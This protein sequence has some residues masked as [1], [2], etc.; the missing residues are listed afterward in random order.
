MK[1]WKVPTHP[2]GQFW[3]FVQCKFVKRLVWPLLRPQLIV[4]DHPW[5]FCVA[6]YFAEIG[7]DHDRLKYFVSTVIVSPCWV[8]HHLV[9]HYHL[10][11]RRR[12][13]LPALQLLCLLWMMAVLVSCIGVVEF[14]V[15]L[16][17]KHFLLVLIWKSNSRLLLFNVPHIDALVDTALFSIADRIQRA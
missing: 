11:R 4:L 13:L 14:V 3:R 6:R 8:H 12:R 15:V 9:L 16:L 7:V 17:E 10:M 1:F 2:P 5:C